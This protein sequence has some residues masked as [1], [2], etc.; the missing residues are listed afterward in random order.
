MNEMKTRYRLTSRGIRGG[1]F[2]CVDKITGKRT[3]LQTT[4]K[5][6]AQQIVEAKNNSVRQPVLNL[7]IAKAYLAGSNSGTAGC[8]HRSGGFRESNVRRYFMASFNISNL[9]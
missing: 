9:A 8:K 4:D 2:Y 3:S 7:Q 5:D 1:M 6:E